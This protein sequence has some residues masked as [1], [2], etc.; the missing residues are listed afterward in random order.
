[1]RQARIV[2]LTFLVMLGGV[3]TAEALGPTS[4]PYGAQMNASQA[5]E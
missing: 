3:V 5:P 2:V 1:M 4:D